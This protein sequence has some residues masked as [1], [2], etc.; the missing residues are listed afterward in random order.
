MVVRHVAAVRVHHFHIDYD[1]YGDA[2]D[3]VLSPAGGLHVRAGQSE[4]DI[5]R[6]VCAGVCVQVGSVSV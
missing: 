4:F 2:G 3:E 6:R 5:H 1:Q